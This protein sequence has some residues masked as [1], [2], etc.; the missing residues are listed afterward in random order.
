MAVAEFTI[1]AVAPSPA[2]CS[3]GGANAAD[4]CGTGKVYDDTKATTGE[5]A[6]AA[7]DKDVA[8]DVNACCK[9]ATATQAKC[10]AGGAD[11]ADFCGTGKVYDDTK[12]TTGECAGA[13]CNKDLPADVTAC[14]KDATATPAKCAAGGANAA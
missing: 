9:V 8:A 10:A 4:F 3:A 7:C 5:C 13:A 11:A 1:R 6:G 12:A 14:C 2:K